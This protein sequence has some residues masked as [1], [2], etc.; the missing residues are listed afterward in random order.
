MPKTGYTDVDDPWPIR[1]SVAAAGK[2]ACV[3]WHKLYQATAKKDKYEKR[4]VEL[5]VLVVA[6]AGIKAEES[7]MQC[8]KLHQT[9]NGK[10]SAEL[11]VFQDLLDKSVAEIDKI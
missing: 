10:R 2:E 3:Q 7:R 6:T 4:S 11:D 9:S 1:P 5:E 8:C